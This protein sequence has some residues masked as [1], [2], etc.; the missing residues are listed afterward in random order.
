[1]LEFIYHYNKLLCPITQ[2][3]D[4]FILYKIYTKF[5]KLL[6]LLAKDK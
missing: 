6:K 2:I 1:M 5:H 3:I 4:N